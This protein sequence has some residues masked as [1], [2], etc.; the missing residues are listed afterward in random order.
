MSGKGKGKEKVLPTSEDNA[1][2]KKKTEWKI[3]NTRILI[4]ICVSIVRK[5]GSAAKFNW[6]HIAKMFNEATGLDYAPR[7]VKNKLDSL[8]REWNTWNKLVNK[9]TGL[10]WDPLNNSVRGSD[11]WWDAMIEV[12][13]KFYIFLFIFCLVLN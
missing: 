3:E 6:V 8:R 7:I 9:E 10:G 11:E 4:D 1:W 2:E 5:K 12:T 13:K